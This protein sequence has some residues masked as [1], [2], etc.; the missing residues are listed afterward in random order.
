MRRSGIG[1][2]IS[3]LS[4]IADWRLAERVRGEV[5]DGLAVT[6]A[7]TGALAVIDRTDSIADDAF[8][9]ALADALVLSGLAMAVAGSSRPCSG[10]DHEIL[11]A[12]DHLYPGTAGHGELAGLASLFACHLRG[13]HAAF[14]EI[15]A[16]LTRHELPRAPGDVGL[17]DEQFAEAVAHAPSTR[18]DRYTVLEHLDLP[19]EEV[20]R[21][22]D[23]YVAALDR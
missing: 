3:N 12:I 14:E 22:V 16:C 17:T 8:L 15:D 11:H 2:A 10:A 6:F 18:P 1:D 4:A 21:R 13:D 5:V 7:R 9:F 19:A 23:A 20:R